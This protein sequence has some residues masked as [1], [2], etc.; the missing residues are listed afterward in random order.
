MFSADWS[1]PETFLNELKTFAV[2]T[3]NALC[4]RLERRR[5]TSDIQLFCCAHVG[6]IRN[7]EGRAEFFVHD[8]ESKWGTDLFG[9]VEP[10][11]L[12]ALIACVERALPVFAASVRSRREG[13]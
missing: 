10:D 13:K 6:L 5:R 7:A 9:R 1:S 12:H 2:T 4:E 8:I 11:A 3:Y